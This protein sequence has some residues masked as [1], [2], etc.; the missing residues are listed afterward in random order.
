MPW[1]PP[2]S[3][4]CSGRRPPPRRAAPPAWPTRPGSKACQMTGSPRS[5]LCSPGAAV[6]SLSFVLAGGE[7]PAPARKAAGLS[8]NNRAFAARKR[9]GSSRFSPET[10][11]PRASFPG[12]RPQLPFRAVPPRS[13]EL[14]EAALEQTL[15]STQTAQRLRK[16]ETKHPPTNSPA[17]KEAWRRAPER[18]AAALPA[19]TPGC[20]QS[21]DHR[22]FCGT[23]PGQE[24]STDN[25]LCA[26]LPSGPALS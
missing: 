25:R 23:A 5:R 24:I 2:Q 18:E 7:V 12:P 10:G 22:G 15:A 16:G 11:G 1:A 4:Q 19:R 14:N 13:S 20:L 3:P 9:Q 26:R 6:G 21:K 17:G 8:L